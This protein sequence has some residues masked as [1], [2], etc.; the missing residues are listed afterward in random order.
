MTIINKSWGMSTRWP[1]KNAWILMA[2]M[3]CFVRTCLFWG[4]A[5][6]VLGSWKSSA[7]SSWRIELV[8]AWTTTIS[9]VDGLTNFL[10]MSFN[11]FREVPILLI[12]LENTWGFLVPYCIWWTCVRFLMDYYSHSRTIGR[13][14]SRKGRKCGHHVHG[15]ERESLVSFTWS[16]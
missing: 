7:I 13:R 10:W 1:L 6:A 9:L 3:S 16:G 8:L 14:M 2:A 4:V 11:Q 5:A 12:Y 15:L